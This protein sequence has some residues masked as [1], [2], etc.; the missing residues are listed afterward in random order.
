VRIL[1]RA[2]QAA[3]AFEL[4][5][6]T[7]GSKRNVIPRDASAVILVPAE[8]EA[9]LR[10]ALAATAAAVAA[11]LGGFDTAVTITAEPAERPE[12]VVI[13]E[14]AERVIAVLLALPNGIVEMSPSVKGL[15]QTSTNV[16]TVKLTAGGVEI[17][18]LQR[19]SVESAKWALGKTVATVARLAG[20]EIDQSGSYPGWKPEPESDLVQVC[21]KAHAAVTGSEAKLIAMH[22]GLECGV[23]G[24][25]YEGMQM[26]ALG[27]QIDGAHSPSERTK[28]SSVQE[29]WKVLVAI[30]ETV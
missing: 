26:I 7:G 25:K 1:A 5:G 13:A 8:K 4:A 21:Q 16:G 29:F 10:S 20:F 22:A 30:L 17:E 3:P 11:E 9:E 12:S 23:I 6:L 28:V 18:T 27:P 2:L 15:V 14:D 24:E 19:S